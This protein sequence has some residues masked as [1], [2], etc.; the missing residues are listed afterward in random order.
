MSV[1]ETAAALQGL[2]QSLPAGANPY[3][4]IDAWL[5][6]SMDHGL[7]DSFFIQLYTLAGLL[8]LNLLVAVTVM[9]LMVWWRKFWLFRVEAGSIRPHGTTPWLLFG[10]LFYIFAIITIFRCVP[11]YKGEEIVRELLGFRT[12]MWFAPWTGGWIA[13]HSLAS[14]YV[15]HL[16]SI[17]RLTALHAQS[18]QRRLTWFF[19]LVLFAFFCVM[20]PMCVV[21]VRQYH[22]A[23]DAFE[24][25][26]RMLKTAGQA[27]DG[28]FDMA[29]LAAALP[30]FEALQSRQADLIST[31]KMLYTTYGGWGIVLGLGVGISAYLH[32]RSLGRTLSRAEGLKTAGTLNSAGERQ[33]AQF[34]KTYKTLVATMWLF[35]AIDAGFT[36][37]SFY[38][39]L[40]TESAMNGYYGSQIVDLTMYYLYFVTGCPVGI[41][42]LWRVI[43]AQQTGTFASSFSHASGNDQIRTFGGS[44][45]NHAKSKSR[46]THVH[47]AIAVDVNTVVAVH[48][49]ESDLD[50]HGR[51]EKFEMVEG[52]YYSS[53]G[54]A[55]VGDDKT[56]ELYFLE[57]QQEGAQD[58]RKL[59]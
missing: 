10:S 7:P 26:D 48:T 24:E 18:W 44:G 13:A 59:R 45:P 35:S 38:V 16:L 37:I 58:Q 41:L 40:H 11:Y 21:A 52:S 46:P 27:Y 53:E 28:T 8:G 36:A 20:T 19:Y 50:V 1:A 47:S 55:D 17:G 51:G 4:A 34:R 32:T 3:L 2:I 30:T 54:L 15:V 39:G 14:N 42:V 22:S 6:S 31:L 9:A 33:T 49:L 25:I 12:M 56:K 5:W 29:S 43:K 57:L 23:M